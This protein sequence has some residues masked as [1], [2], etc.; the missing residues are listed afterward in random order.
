MSAIAA[1]SAWRGSVGWLVSLMT[2][3]QGARGWASDDDALVAA[4]RGGSDDAF[5]VLVQR[6]QQGLRAF[7]RRTCSDWTLADDLAQEVFLAAWSGIGKLQPG[8]NLRA[9]LCGIGYRKA[10]AAIR[11]DRRSR[12]RD[13]EYSKAETAVLAPSA[14][15]RMTLDGAMSELPMDQRACV[16]LC[17]GAEFTHAEA[18]LALGMPLGSVKSHVQRGRARLL[19]A[20]GVPD[21]EG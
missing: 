4:I 1:D 9:W 8:A 19:R 6:H 15:D 14:E 13:A 16:A 17:L 12:L 5:A 20:L 3:S 18:A 10:L 2:R 21:D 11:T 7:L